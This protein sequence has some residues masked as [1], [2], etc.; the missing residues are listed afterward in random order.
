MLSQRRQ[1]G[2]TPKGDVSVPVSGGETEA[3]G[4]RPEARWSWVG[5]RPTPRNLSARAA[6][7][8]PRLRE[9]SARLSPGASLGHRPGLSM[10]S[11]ASAFL[12]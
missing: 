9:A 1:P 12:P 3:P 7:V 2:Q 5:P 6:P 10:A 11:V 8:P 4:G